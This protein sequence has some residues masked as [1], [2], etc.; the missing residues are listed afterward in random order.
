MLKSRLRDLS[1]ALLL[2]A[3]LYRVSGFFS[4]GKIY[5]F[6]NCNPRDRHLDPLISSSSSTACHRT[7]APSSASKHRFT[8]HC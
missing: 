2:Q 5:Y 6:N 7:C 8:T 4:K 1:L 3:C